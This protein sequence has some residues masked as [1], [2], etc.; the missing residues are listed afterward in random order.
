[1]SDKK[2]N[3]NIFIRR[4]SFKKQERLKFYNLSRNYYL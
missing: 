1:M 3:I 4:K 2:M